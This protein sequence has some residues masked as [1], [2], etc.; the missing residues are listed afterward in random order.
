MY[1]SE[2]FVQ[3]VPVKHAQVCG[4][5]PATSY[6]VQVSAYSVAGEGPRGSVTFVTEMTSKFT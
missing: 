4:L 3:N 6:K 1:L 5:L 2:K